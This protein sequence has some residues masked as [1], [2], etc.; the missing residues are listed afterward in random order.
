[1][2]RG[3]RHGAPARHPDRIDPISWVRRGGDQAQE[4]VARRSGR[5]EPIGSPVSGSA[6]GASELGT[7]EPA[8]AWRSARDEP[9]GPS[10][11]ATGADDH[12]ASDDG[13]IR[14]T[15]AREDRKEAAM[16]ISR[17]MFAPGLDVE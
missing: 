3:A 8:P 7:G 16:G 12:P 14:S 1:M 17:N 9:I 4:P 6:H 10:V 13:L 15:A 2:L 5:D 11:T